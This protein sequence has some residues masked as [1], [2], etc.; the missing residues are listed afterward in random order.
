MLAWFSVTE[1]IEVNLHE[2]KKQKSVR[3]FRDPTISWTHRFRN[4]PTTQINPEVV[5]MSLQ[6]SDNARLK[7]K[8][9]AHECY[10]H[11]I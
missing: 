8:L 6:T 11:H 3:E 10:L 5:N 7:V 4:E 2:L 1:N 9:L